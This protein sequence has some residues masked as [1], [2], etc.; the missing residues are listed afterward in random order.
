MIQ[1]MN[2]FTI[3]TD[4][5]DATRSFYCDLLGLKEGYR[6]SVG[7]PGL[8]LYAGD[9]AI[10]HVVERNPL[11]EPRSGVLDHIAFTA[12]DLSAT[13]QLLN[14]H[15]TDFRLMRQAD[16]GIWQVFIFDPNKVK[17]ELDF[18]STE[19]APSGTET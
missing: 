19:Q 11:P 18:A 10:L 3:L 9:Q 5:L 15:G 7:V 13:L 17:L 12:T 4:N 16:S 2:H 1:G 14:R 8:W 6:P